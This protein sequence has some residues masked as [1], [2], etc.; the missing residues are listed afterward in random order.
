MT[1]SNIRGKYG[2]VT[3]FGGGSINSTD[4]MTQGLSEKDK[5]EEQMLTGA[6]P[7]QGDADPTTF[8]VG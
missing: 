2:S 4:L 6:S 3:L 5:L 7:G 8:F 1:V